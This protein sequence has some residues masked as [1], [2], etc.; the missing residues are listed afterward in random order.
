MLNT[1][2]LI[3]EDILAAGVVVILAAGLFCAG[4]EGPATA[5]DFTLEDLSGKTLTLSQFKG[6]VL[7][8]NFWATW[9]P[10]CR[11]EI[12]EFVAAYNKYRS[13]GLAIIGLCLDRLG[14]DD[15]ASFVEENGISYPI[16]FATEQVVDDYRPGRYIPV[17]I[18]IDKEGRVRNRT[19]GQMDGER[20][21][22]L[23]LEYNG[24]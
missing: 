12:P 20:L 7:V 17:T 5:P 4:Q 6:K 22:R 8:L 18:V 9:C 15:V 21:E 11:A 16:A 23:F 24:E 19:V 13:E 2:G 3:K 1:E 10:P 14:A